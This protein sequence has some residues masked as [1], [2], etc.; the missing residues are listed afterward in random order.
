LST[1]DML[2]EDNKQGGPI[3]AF[4]SFYRDD[5]H[6]NSAS[7]AKPGHKSVDEIGK[8]KNS[9][10]VA[11]NEA[12]ATIKEQPMPTNFSELK[13]RSLRRRTAYHQGTAPAEKYAPM[14]DAD[15]IRNTQDKQMAG[16]ELNT[17][18][19]NPDEKV[20]ELH[21]RASLDERR[22]RR[23][24]LV[25]KAKTA[26]TGEVKTY[27]QDG[28]DVKT[29]VGPDGKEKALAQAAEDGQSEK[30]TPTRFATLSI[31]R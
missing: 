7:Q 17:S 18:V 3:A 25:E 4:M 11:R 5:L 27:K 28:K 22:L 20:K 24:A 6:K 14:G 1:G 29:V 21:Q 31:N 30:K 26:A 10:K 2:P 13:E 12:S 8:S 15:K 19:D 9:N 16:D 23:A